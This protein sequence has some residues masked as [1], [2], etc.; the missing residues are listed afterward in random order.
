MGGSSIV[1]LGLVVEGWSDELPKEWSEELPEVWSEGL[2]KEW[3]EELLEVWSEELPKV[4]GVR[5]K[6]ASIAKIKNVGHKLQ[7]KY[8]SN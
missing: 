4:L 8:L 3:S 1:T 2:P 5:L 6:L 7:A